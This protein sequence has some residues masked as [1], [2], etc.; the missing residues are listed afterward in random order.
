MTFRRVGTVLVLALAA[1]LF[2]LVAIGTGRALAAGLAAAAAVFALALYAQAR[3]Y[4]TTLEAVSA[5]GE[6]ALALAPGALAIFFSF[7]GGGYSPAPVAFVALLLALALALR[8]WL[9]WEPF[10]GYGPLAM[11][12][13][14]S[15]ALYTGWVALSSQWSH[16]PG[17]ALVEA[18]RALLYLLAIA[19]FA[20]VARS[21]GRIRLMVTGLAAAAVV[22]CLV[23]LVTRTMPD[24]WPIGP[25]LQQGRLSYPLTYWNALGLLAAL[26]L[27]LCL[28]LSSSE[29][30]PPV[31]RVLGAAAF[32]VLGASLYFTFSRG[33]IAVAI[34]GLVAYA[35]LGRPRGLLGALLACGPATAVAVATAYNA[36][37][38]ASDNPTTAAATS[39]G[40][41]VALV[42][43][44][45]VLGAGVIRALALPIDGAL[46]R[47]RLR[48][49]MRVWVPATLWSAGVILAAAAF[50]ALHGPRTVS[51][52]YNR[53]VKGNAVVIS[54]D[55]RSRLG[56]P[57]N[58]R[59][60]DQWR[61]AW[62]GYTRETFRGQGAGTYE[63]LWN[64]RRPVTF[65]IKDAHSLY[66]EV[67]D[68]LGLV[69][70]ALL[71]IALVSMAIAFARGLWRAHDRYPYAALLAALLAW[72]VRAGIDWDWEMPAITL[73]LFCAGGAAA[74]VSHRS[75]ARPLRLVRPIRL[76]LSLACV[77]LALVPAAVAVSE[78]RLDTAQAA[79]ARGDCATAEKEAGRSLD[80]VSFRPEP[81]ELIA[82]CAARRNATPLAI[83]EI[84]QAIRRDPGNWRYRYDLAL[85]L[86]ASGRD[87]VPTARDAAALNPREP[88]A[89]SEARMLAGSDAKALARRLI[90]GGQ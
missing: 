79:F 45:C 82:F 24:L 63:N 27:V 6:R 37:L 25:D 57:G 10:A 47:V 49:R 9:A 21:T 77:A 23:G 54:G 36:D 58:N 78:H 62:K 72:L 28:H 53:F 60:I 26:G 83:S 13:M 1:L 11:V 38:L 19:F 71:A 15:F 32:P 55:L 29:R 8:I 68:E 64:Q 67:M 75:R 48:A 81:R 87:G 17:R 16:A 80:V 7:N 89:A 76:G 14:G 46:A 41:H 86:S 65:A 84:R 74:A 22:V 34:L 35:L 88:T 18:D 40:H 12:A 33:A 85:L 51:H 2:A 42:V 61:V 69:G 31:V 4:E 20:S 39:Q 56:D 66:V 90:A 59:R 3:H 44:A 50:I 70:I 52:N 73:W 5:A 43:V 30:E